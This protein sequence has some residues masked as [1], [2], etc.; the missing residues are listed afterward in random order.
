MTT[1]RRTRNFH[2]VKR[3]GALTRK[4]KRAGQ[5]NQAYARKHYH[6]PGLRGQQAR[7]AVIARKWRKGGKRR[8]HRSS[9]RS[10]KRD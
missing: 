1:K 10:M 8:H 5:S 7:F 9:H 2:P 3:P 6:D 4:A